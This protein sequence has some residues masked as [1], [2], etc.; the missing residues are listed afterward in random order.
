MGKPK[1]KNSWPHSWSK[2]SKDNWGDRPTKPRTKKTVSPLP[3][4]TLRRAKPG[5]DLAVMQGYGPKGA[6]A[7]ERFRQA[8]AALDRKRKKRLAKKSK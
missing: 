5:S 7:A 4:S 8:Q 2:S 3:K 6:P 1:K